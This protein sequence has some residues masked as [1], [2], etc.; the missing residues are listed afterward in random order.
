MTK[1]VNINEINS[2]EDEA[3]APLPPVAGCSAAQTLPLDDNTQ[4]MVHTKIP[5]PFFSNTVCCF[6]MLWSECFGRNL[7]YL[8]LDCRDK[9]T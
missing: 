7:D 3:R 4:D 5:N 9:N 1:P 8:I 6:R 2:K